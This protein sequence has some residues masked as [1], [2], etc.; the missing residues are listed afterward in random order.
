[1]ETI[2]PLDAIR[3]ELEEQKRR[4]LITFK[5][6]LQL[7]SLKAPEREE[8]DRLEKAVAKLTEECRRKE[9]QL[10]PLRLT[11]HDEYVLEMSDLCDYEA[12]VFAQLTGEL[13]KLV[14]EIRLQRA[15]S[16]SGHPANRR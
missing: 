14:R 12:K 16:L 11:D 15:K 7:G 1:M 5:E 8:F 9:T 2:E 4:Y 10:E 6:A 13:S 3:A